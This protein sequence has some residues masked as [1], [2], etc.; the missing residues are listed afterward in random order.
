LLQFFLVFFYIELLVFLVLNVSEQCLTILWSD[1]R[2]IDNY[3]EK[4]CLLSFS[5]SLNNRVAD[6]R[7]SGIS[8]WVC[9]FLLFP[10]L[11]R[12]LDV[13]WPFWKFLTLWIVL[14]N[15]EMTDPASLA[16]SNWAIFELVITRIF[17]TSKSNDDFRDWKRK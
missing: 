14:V 3:S 2:I 11:L 5:N 17:Q 1:L 12:R 15:L 6:A 8:S 16:G 9:I 4:G 10:H 7:F 13:L